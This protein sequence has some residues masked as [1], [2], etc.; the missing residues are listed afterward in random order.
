MR[1]AIHVAVLV[2]GTA[3]SAGQPPSEDAWRRSEALANAGRPA[4]ALAA[5]DQALALLQPHQRMTAWLHTG[6]EADPRLT[7]LTGMLRRLSTARS[8]T[9]PL[10]ARGNVYVG[11]SRGVVRAWDART[12]EPVGQ[13]DAGVPVC[14]TLCAIEGGIAFATD[15][16]R[17]RVA[18]RTLE[19]WFEWPE[20]GD[21]PADPEVRDI[22]VS[23]RIQPVRVTPVRHHGRLYWPMAGGGSR[24]RGPDGELTHPAR[25]E[26]TSYRVNADGTMPV[27]FGTGGAYRVDEHLRPVELLAPSPTR[28]LAAVV[29]GHVVAVLSEQRDSTA[30]WLLEAWTLKGRKLP[31][32]YP[33]HRYAPYFD[34]APWLL[35][36]GDGVL[37]VGR[38]LVYCDPRRSD[39]AWR[40]FPGGLRDAEVAAFRRPAV[41]ERRAYFTHRF[42]ELYVFDLDRILGGAAKERTAQGGGK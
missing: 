35:P 37:L 11:D 23:I 15:D 29:S 25:L 38:E 3:C 1:G 33:T 28:A 8:P 40:F 5:V 6:R 17:L 27:A 39:P 2:L 18:S 24:S 13:L 30:P 22:R 41:H 34:T 26:V 36:F 12:L 32:H 19:P 16:R 7:E 31:L 42:G 4:D 14:H 20:G 9:P 10:V 21:L